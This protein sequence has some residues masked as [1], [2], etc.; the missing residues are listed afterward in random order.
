M[1]EDITVMEIT[2]HT[3][4]KNFL[5]LDRILEVSP[6]HIV[7]IRTYS[8]E[9]V[10][11]ALESVAQLGAFFCRKL[12][13]FSKHIFLLTIVRCVLPGES[14]ISGTLFISGK[15][16]SRSDSAF[17]L[18]IRAEKENSILIEGTFIFGSVPYAG[19]FTREK[20]QTHY[21]EVFSCLLNATENG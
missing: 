9:H 21:R 15:L 10:T 2:I 18:E 7:G 20:L 6:H 5:F 19:A 14:L 11:H 12:T 16:I 1:G 4:L 13:D 8:E 17:Q 3:G